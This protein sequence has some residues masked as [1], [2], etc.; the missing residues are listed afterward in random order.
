MKFWS[1]K[2]LFP[3]LSV[4]FLLGMLIFLAALQYKWL[5]QISDAEREH[6]HNRLENDTKRFAE[7]FDREIQSVYFNFQ[8]DAEDFKNQNWNAFNKSFI[9]RKNQTQFPELIKDIYFIKTGDSQT[10]LKFDEKNATF[11]NAD[12]TNDLNNISQ[13]LKDGE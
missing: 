6:L 11:E 5:G 7:D 12:W 1:V 3:V 9:S 10:L 13:K 4:I 8:I 2:N